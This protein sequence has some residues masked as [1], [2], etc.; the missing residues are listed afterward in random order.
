MSDK[1]WPGYC[2]ACG[3]ELNPPNAT[4]CRVCH[5]SDTDET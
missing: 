5:A 2:Q 1:P 4:T 3:S